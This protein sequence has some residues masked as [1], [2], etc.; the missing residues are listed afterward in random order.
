MLS[1]FLF[2]LY[3]ALKFLRFLAR[4]VCCCPV[5]TTLIVGVVG[6]FIYKKIF[7]V[8]TIRPKPEAYKKDYK[9]DVVYLYQFKRTRKCPNLSPFCMKVEVFCRAYNIPYEV[10]IIPQIIFLITYNSST[11]NVWKWFRFVMRS[12]VGLETDH[13]H[14]L[15]STENILQTPISSKPVFANISMFQ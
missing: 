3:R 1:F 15:S 8:P 12:V 14:S 13:S 5:T 11:E 4:M 10:C 9:K 2:K 6:Y 7:K